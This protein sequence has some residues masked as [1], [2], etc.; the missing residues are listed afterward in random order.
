[1]SD[2]DALSPFVVKVLQT[3]APPIL[4]FGRNFLG[5][6]KLDHVELVALGTPIEEVIK[7]YGEP[8]ESKKDEDFDEATIHTFSAG[9]F[10]EAVISEWQGKAWSITYWSAYSSPA[11]DLQCMLK[12]FGEGIGWDN[13]E[14]GYWFFRNDNKVR[15]W[16]SAVPAIGVATVD[17]MYAESDAKNAKRAAAGA[18]D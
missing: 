9:P 18:R 17:Y 2:N 5:W 1:M 13:V 15:L 10:H 14:T 12:F 8:L 11:A 4:W 7:L 6:N 16:C 3:L